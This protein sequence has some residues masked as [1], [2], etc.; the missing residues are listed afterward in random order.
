[1]NTSSQRECFLKGPAINLRLCSH[2]ARCA[3]FVLLNKI[4][5]LKEGQLDSLVDIARSLNP[6]AKVGHQPPTKQCLHAPCLPTQG[7]NMFSLIEM[8]Y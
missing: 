4:D 2:N 6:L 5:T 7:I 1:M 3:D 8:C